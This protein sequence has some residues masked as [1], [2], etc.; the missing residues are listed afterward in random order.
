VLGKKRKEIILKGTSFFFS[1]V[2]VVAIGVS[3]WVRFSL[4]PP[5]FVLVP[6]WTT[7][8]SSSSY[9]FLFPKPFIIIISTK[10]FYDEVSVL[11][12]PIFSSFCLWWD[13]FISKKGKQ[14]L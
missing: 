7:F 8:G 2:L 9:L 5:T 11:L 1:T 3:R 4:P 13:F 12:L 14:L 10:F 6:H